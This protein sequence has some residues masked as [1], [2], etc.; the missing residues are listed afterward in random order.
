MATFDLFG[1]RQ[2]E[3]PAIETWCSENCQGKWE[4][5]YRHYQ[6]LSYNGFCDGF[7]MPIAITI[8]SDDEALMCM[9]RFGLVPCTL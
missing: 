6:T 3:V 1:H 4:I 8:E 7:E 2:F 9:L 5:L